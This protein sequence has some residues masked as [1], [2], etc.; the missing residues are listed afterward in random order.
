MLK[1]E[2]LVIVGELLC[3]VWE[4]D[5]PMLVTTVGVMPE[6]VSEKSVAVLAIYRYS[7]GAALGSVR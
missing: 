1:G 6:T 7:L 4:D 3:D 5:G 2:L